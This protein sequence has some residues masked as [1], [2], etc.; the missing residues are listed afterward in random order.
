MAAADEPDIKAEAPE[1][2]RRQRQDL[3]GPSR[4]LRPTRPASGVATGARKEFFYWTDDG[5]LAGLRYDQWKI[6]F[7]EQR[8]EGLGLAK[9]LTPLRAPLLF[10]LRR[11]VRDGRPRIRR[12]REWYVDRMFVMVPAQA[13]VAKDL[14]T[15]K[16]FPPRQKPG[17]FSVG[18]A[19]EKLQSAGQNSN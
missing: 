4:R 10:N 13:I 6:V 1:R 19:L 11:S 9:P 8:H 5:D 3:Q 12:V 15:L 16:E 2:L 18:D 7:L 17:S 14:Q